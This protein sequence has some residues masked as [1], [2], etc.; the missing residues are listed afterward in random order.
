[1]NTPRG[2]LLVGLLCFSLGALAAEREVEV[3]ADTARAQA[4]IADLGQRLRSALMARMQAEGPVAA[5]AFCHEE[6]PGIADAVANAH[7]LSIGRTSDRPRSPMNTPGDW[8][9]AVLADFAQR[10]AAG[11]E[12]QA[13]VHSA[14]A[15]TF[16]YARGIRVEGPCLV[17]HGTAVPET[18]QTAIQSRY[19]QDRATG[20]SEGELRGMFWVEITQDEAVDPRARIPMSSAQTAALRAEMRHRLETQQRLIAALAAGDWEAA[21]AAA[22]EGTRGRHIGADFRSALPEGWFRFA[23]PMHQAFAAAR[24]EARGA[25]RLQVAL[26]HVARAGEFCT[27]CHATFRTDT[28]APA[29]TA[30]AH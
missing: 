20:Y 22:D 3:D 24:E 27:G 7:G 29:L 23:R 19:P 15:E 10:H 2:F 12:P 18:V 13:L 9:L 8:Q 30:A 5:V 21:A 28:A 11:A 25:R 6:A 26:G 1:M 17:C 16:R 14:R 4:A